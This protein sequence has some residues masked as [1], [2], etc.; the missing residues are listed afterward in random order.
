MDCTIRRNVSKKKTG[1]NV[2]KVVWIWKT[3][4]HHV[5]SKDTAAS[6]DTQ[7]DNGV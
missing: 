4:S 2:D 1:A 3:K 7:S 6:G 5:Q